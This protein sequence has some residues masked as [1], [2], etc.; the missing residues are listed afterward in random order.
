MDCRR[1]GKRKII[2]SKFSKFMLMTLML[3]MD[4]KLMRTMFLNLFEEKSDAH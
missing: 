2:S 3:V 1:I 4:I